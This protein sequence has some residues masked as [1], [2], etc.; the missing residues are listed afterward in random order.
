MQY[1]ITTN[2]EFFAIGI[3]KTYD[4]TSLLDFTKGMDAHIGY[5]NN[6]S[7]LYQ[8]TIRFIQQG[9]FNTLGTA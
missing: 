4:S 1:P 3:G 5:A 8:T 7:T 6:F 2:S 9:L